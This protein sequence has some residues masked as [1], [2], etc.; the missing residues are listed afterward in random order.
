MPILTINPATGRVTRE[1]QETSPDA[2]EQIL[3]RVHTVSHAWSQTRFSER[4]RCMHEAARLLRERAPEHAR[5]M[6]EEMG[7]PLPQGRAESEK[8][9]WVCEY[10]AERAE[11]FLTP[12]PAEADGGDAYV[13][14][15]PLGVVL[16]IMPWNFPFWQVLRFAAPALM[17]GNGALLKHAPG[18][19]GSAVAIETL[20]RDAGV[21][22]G[23][24]ANLAIAESR[25]A[26][27]IEDRRVHAVTLTGST[28][29]GRAVARA[30]GGA[31]KKTV[32]EL[33]GSDPY[34]VLADADVD[35][36]ASACVTSRLI[37]G[38]Q[39]CIAAKRFIVEEPIRERFTQRV[40]E[41]MSQKTMHDPLSGKDP[42][43]GPMAREDLRNELHGQVERSVAA[44]AKL[45]LGGRVPER[46]GAWYP[47][48]VLADV[49]PGTPAY[50][51][52]TFGPVA[53]IIAARNEDDA[54]AIANASPYGLGAAVFTGDRAR[55]ER[56]AR[57]KLDAGC[58]FVNDFVKSDP[59]LPFGGIKESGYGR[60]LSVFGIREFVNVKSI[61]VR[62]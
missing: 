37:N 26:A 6:A 54:I 35:A 21:P 43:L 46:D 40:V 36:A 3:T 38:G 39:S 23:L 60:E 4:A 48:T 10:Y 13:A 18:V 12:E 30:A 34:V 22:D 5:I 15:Q 16:A 53:S 52:E 28:R 45:L 19:Q 27:V 24:F 49:R 20:L 17:A 9:A 33:G 41:L 8:C 29:A 31:L 59:R 14:Y 61:F 1:W 32:L 25:V 62:E 11:R 2:L 57:E 51:E 47:P 55:G 42:D 58:C 50:S 56:I 44:G 7:K